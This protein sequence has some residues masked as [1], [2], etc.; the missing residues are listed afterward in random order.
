METRETCLRIGRQRPP[1]VLDG[2]SSPWIPWDTFLHTKKLDFASKHFV[3]FVTIQVENVLFTG[4]HSEM[5]LFTDYM[6]AQFQ[7]LELEYDNICVNGTKFSRDKDGIRMSQ[8]ATILELQQFPLSAERRRMH[9]ETATRAERLFYMT[10]VGSILF[11]G[12]VTLPIAVIGS[13]YRC[14]V[15][16]THNITM[17]LIRGCYTFGCHIITHVSGFYVPSFHVSHILILADPVQATFP[18]AIS[19]CDGMSPTAHHSLH[20]ARKTSCHN[21]RTLA[22]SSRSH[23]VIQ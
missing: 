19:I 1:M 15:S 21:S 18:N 5:M 12:Y 4:T 7:L 22:W 10:T 6:K 17:Y 9:E 3:L 11:V 23:S 13:T 14:H 8:R 20:R 2:L 16:D